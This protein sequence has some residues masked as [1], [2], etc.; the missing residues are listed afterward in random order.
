MYDPRERGKYIEKFYKNIND[1]KYTKIET[2]MVNSNNE[3]V[4]ITIEYEPS[5]KFGKEKN[6]WIKE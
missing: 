6:D 1:I 5:I 2:T 4:S 3:I